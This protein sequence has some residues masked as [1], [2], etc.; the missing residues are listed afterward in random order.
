MPSQLCDHLQFLPA[1]RPVSDRKYLQGID[2]S[3][4]PLPLLSVPFPPVEDFV[5]ASICLTL[6]A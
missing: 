6:M 2:A 1:L 3:E 5:W 4:V